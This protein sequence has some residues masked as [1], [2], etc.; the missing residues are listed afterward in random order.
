MYGQSSHQALAAGGGTSGDRFIGDRRGAVAVVYAVLLVTMLAAL[1]MGLDMS[2]G[3][4]VQYQLDLAADTA[5]VSC[6]TTWETFMEQGLGAATP[7]N[8]NNLLSNANAAAQTVLQNVFYAQA[9]SYGATYQAAAAAPAEYIDFGIS[10]T[11]GC[12]IQIP[13]QLHAELTI[14]LQ[15]LP[16]WRKL[17]DLSTCTWVAVPSRTFRCHRLLLS[18]SC[19]DTSASMMVGATPNDQSLIATF[20]KQYDNA[21]YCTNTAL[22]NGSQPTAQGHP[23][24]PAN[25]GTVRGP[26]IAP[27]AFA[28]HDLGDPLKSSQMMEGETNAHNPKPTGLQT[29]TSSGVGA[30]ATTRFDVLLQA[31]LNDP[32]T[33][34]SSFCGGA[35]EIACTNICGSGVL[36][37]CVYTNG[38]LD[39]EG[40]LPYIRDHFTGTNRVSSLSTFSYALYGFNGGINYV[41]ES[42][43]KVEI[44]D[45]SGNPATSPVCTPGQH[46]VT[47]PCDTS[48]YVQAPTSSLATIGS[49]I[50]SLTIGF[51]T[52]LNS[53]LPA[54]GGAAVMDQ[55]AKTTVIPASGTGLTISS[56]L[57]YVIIVTDGMNSDRDANWGGGAGVAA[58]TYC[59]QLWGRSRP[60][61]AQYDYLL[62][63][64]L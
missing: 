48:Q 8:Y 39:Y 52:H 50:N 57:V 10:R 30:G 32:K 31:L 59:N 3:L 24:P 42:N 25:G 2:N 18:I 61:M 17:S 33:Q 51:D 1:G 15:T 45:A 29:I 16:T 63:A 23:C 47:T 34:S 44:T 49:A 41:P 6:G 19:G 38:I 14:W 36:P 43:T 40:L 22:L 35:N 62:V 7:A 20:V 56:P 11:L 37:A 12:V 26:D 46:P 53:P 9:G 4:I 5:A 55:L 58:N 13:G 27:C 54:S 21:Y 60:S 28:C 64:G